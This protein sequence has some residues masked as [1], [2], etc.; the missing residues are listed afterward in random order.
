MKRVV[1]ASLA[2]AMMLPEAGGREF[3]EEQPILYSA[4]ESRDPMALLARDWAEGRNQ[5][6]VTTP[7][8]KQWGGWHVIG[9]HEGVLHME[10]G[11]K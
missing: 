1:I 7:L 11:T 3:F 8:E 9:N 2:A 5:I 4:T 6:H 10:K